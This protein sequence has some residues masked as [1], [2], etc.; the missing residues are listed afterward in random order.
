MR[1]GKC[2]KPYTSASHAAGFRA[3]ASSHNIL[4]TASKGKEGHAVRH[5]L[6]LGSGGKTPLDSH[7]TAVTFR[8]SN[9]S[10]NST[11]AVSPK[12]SLVFASNHCIRLLVLE[13]PARLKL[14]VVPNLRKMSQAGVMDSIPSV[15]PA[16]VDLEKIEG[17]DVQAIY[18]KTANRLDALFVHGSASRAI[19]KHLEES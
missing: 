14:R 16:I 19:A 13:H 10:Q 5:Q 12:T 4:A 1:K 11:V 7:A 15:V 2:A 3:T 6:L 8:K 9:R 17:M 18:N